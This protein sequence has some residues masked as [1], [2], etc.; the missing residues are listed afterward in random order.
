MAN[1]RSYNFNWHWTP[2]EW[3]WSPDVGRW[4]PEYGSPSTCVAFDVTTSG[5][6]PIEAY[7]YWRETVFYG[8]DADRNS[9][10]RAAGFSA[11]ASG[12]LAPRAEFYAY[13]SDGVSGRR[14]QSQARADGNDDVTLGAIFAGRRRHRDDR[15]SVVSSAVG[16]LFFYDAARPSRVVWEAHRGSHLV[17]RRADVVEVLGQDVPPAGLV[18]DA[19]RRSSLSAH[20][21]ARM[22][23]LSDS[24]SHLTHLERS[25]LLDGTVELALAALQQAV[26]VAKGGNSGQRESL[27]AAARRLIDK[28]LDDPDLDAG[29]VALALGCSR[30]TL[31]RAFSDHGLTIYGY[32][33]ELRLQRVRKLLG[34]AERV[35]SIAELA[36]ASGF[37]DPSNFGRVFRRRFGQSPREAATTS[38]RHARDRSEEP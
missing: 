24:L 20:L 16:D 22:R 33:R 21:G 3:A 19:L 26:C 37:R 32:M 30:A 9:N 12:L 8:F 6:A 23:L 14:T 31:Y 28:N 13:Q 25:L 17:L 29:R 7:D 1:E 27:F 38:M 34:A 2:D 18:A 10:G 11:H 36:R 35:E 5:L 4:R 15:D